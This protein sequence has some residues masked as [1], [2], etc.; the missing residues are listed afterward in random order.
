MPASAAAAS[1]RPP[2]TATVVRRPAR[3]ASR[4]TSGEKRYMPA[5]CTLMTR[6]MIR[7]V[8][9]SGPPAWPMCTGVMTMT[10]TMTEWETTTAVR[11]EP[12]VR[13]GPDRA[14]RRPVAPR[15]GHPRRRRPGGGR[16][17]GGRGA[18]GQ[19]RRPTSRTPRRRR[20]GAAERGQSE[21]RA[22]VGARTGQ[23]RAEHRA[24][25]RRPDHQRQVASAALR[26]RE[27]GGGV[28]RLQAAGR[29][30]TEGEQPDQ[31]QRQG[32][33]RRGDDRQDRPEDGDG[34]ARGQPRPPAGPVAEPGQRARR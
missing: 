19:D 24:D 18:A 25:G 5:T 3:S 22:E 11:P 1:S 21:R 16:A 8:V 32:G 28:A 10:P 15:P 13:R 31:E 4:P 20:R 6:P 30:G 14:H 7:S 2:P 29:R 33:Q 9:P 26:R 23:V 27:V 12:T 34:V 17:A